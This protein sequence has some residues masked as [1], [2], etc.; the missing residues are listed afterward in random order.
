[1]KREFQKV[2]SS[3][4][5]GRTG[6]RQKNSG[7][8]SREEVSLGRRHERER[9]ARDRP[10]LGKEERNLVG[11]SGD[12]S[13]KKRG[14]PPPVEWKDRKKDSIKNRALTSLRR[15]KGGVANGNHRG[16]NKNLPGQR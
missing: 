13:E 16:G 1:M 4:S 2:Y 11:P 5:A 6:K 3:P 14:E 10:T 8:T 9:S 7:S 15:R 12:C